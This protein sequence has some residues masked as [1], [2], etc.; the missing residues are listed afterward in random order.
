L[1]NNVTRFSAAIPSPQS[2]GWLNAGWARFILPTSPPP[3]SSG[4]PP[5]W[6]S[7]RTTSRYRFRP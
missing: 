5:R 4:R 6:A 7:F 2:T 1:D 3:E